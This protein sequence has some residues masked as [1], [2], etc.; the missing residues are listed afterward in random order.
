MDPSTIILTN[1]ASHD[2]CAFDIRM[3]FQ[4]ATRPILLLVSLK[5]IE[6][7][8][9]A[10]EGIKA[11]SDVDDAAF[12]STADTAQAAARKAADDI[13]ADVL[14]PT[15]PTGNGG[16]VAEKLKAPHC[17]EDLAFLVAEGLTGWLPLLSSRPSLATKHTEDR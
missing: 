5:R 13:G 17:R 12:G 7:G 3:V 10:L 8:R 15:I 2:C 4:T 9:Q 6:A 1:T 11:C 14:F 16:R